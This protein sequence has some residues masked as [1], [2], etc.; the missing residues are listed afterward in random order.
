MRIFVDESLTLRRKYGPYLTLQV[1]E[2]A[3]GSN[4]QTLEPIH[5]LTQRDLR[6]STTP[7]FVFND[8][9]LD[10]QNQGRTFQITDRKGRVLHK[11]HKPIQA[12][13]FFG[14]YL[15]YLEEGSFDSATKT[16]PVRFIDLHYF[17]GSIGNVA[18][19]VYT[20]PLKEES[21][22][23][24]GF[25]INNGRLQ[26]NEHSLD[27]RA[28]RFLGDFYRVFFNLSVSLVDPQDPLHLRGFD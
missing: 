7:N 28:F 8:F 23:L 4:I 24:R 5:T 1:V 2:G 15:V 10:T 27:Y 9:Y 12:V 16:L 20:L 25:K 11:F 3:T 21:S 26:I 22:T 6:G 18:L 17:R 13:G 19:P 14:Q